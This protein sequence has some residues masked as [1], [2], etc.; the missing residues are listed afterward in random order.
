VRHE[1]A[2]VFAPLLTALLALQGSKHGCERRSDRLGFFP[3]GAGCTQTLFPWIRGPELS[4]AGRV[5]HRELPTPASLAP[6]AF[7][8]FRLDDG[9]REYFWRSGEG[10]TPLSGNSSYLRLYSRR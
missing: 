4:E 5:R 9:G 6:L 3:G 10:F 2:A 8:R 7:R 1:F